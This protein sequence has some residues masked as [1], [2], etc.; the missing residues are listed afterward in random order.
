[1][2]RSLPLLVLFSLPLSLGAAEP[3]ATVKLWPGKAPG[4]G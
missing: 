1:M 2:T 3:A 4:F